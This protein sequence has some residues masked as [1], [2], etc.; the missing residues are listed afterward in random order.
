MVQ[1]SAGR[2]F[3]IKTQIIGP[4]VDNVG[5]VLNRVITYTGFGYDLEADPRHSEII[6]EQMGVSGSGGK[7]AACLRNEEIETTEQEEKLDPGDVTLFR[8]VSARS[9][10]LGPDRPE[11]VYASKEVC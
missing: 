4:E 7:T 3:A 5:K 11:M 6:V 10:C 8:G 2:R 9:M 1:K